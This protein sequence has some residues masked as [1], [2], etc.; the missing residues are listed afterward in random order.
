MNRKSK[1]GKWLVVLSSFFAIALAGQQAMALIPSAVTGEQ[2]VIACFGSDPVTCGG[3]QSNWQTTNWVAGWNRYAGQVTVDGQLP[4]A[5]SGVTISVRG[6]FTAAD[7]CRY[8]VSDLN[9][10][11]LLTHFVAA[12]GGVQTL[13]LGAPTVVSGQAL[14]VSCNL[15]TNSW[16]GLAW[17]Q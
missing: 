7:G 11:L 10:N 14:T 4:V 3:Q 2:F 16:I 1:V 6:S 15:S 12:T 9:G 8:I 13:N 17:Q 5:N